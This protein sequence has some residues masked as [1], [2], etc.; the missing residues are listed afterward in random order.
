[1]E[2]TESSGVPHP[3]ATS[4]AS[5]REMAVA[6]GLL[7][8]VAAALGLHDGKTWGQAGQNA[9]QGSLAGLGGLGDVSPELLA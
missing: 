8:P 3:P 2:K 4:A 9:T 1:M 7:I 6:F 5:I